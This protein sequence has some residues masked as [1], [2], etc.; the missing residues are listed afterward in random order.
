ME[1]EALYVAPEHSLVVF[2]HDGTGVEPQFDLSTRDENHE[3]VDHLLL[4]TW[5]IEPHPP[6]RSLL[7]P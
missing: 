7:Q 5:S 1:S 4:C 6:N 3:H 2:P